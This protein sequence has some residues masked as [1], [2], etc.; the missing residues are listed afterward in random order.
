M[1][2]TSLKAAL[3][4]CVLLV[5]MTIW[6]LQ[7]TIL[8]VIDHATIL[9][10]NGNQPIRNGVIVIEGQ[11]IRDIG[12]RGNIRPGPGVTILDANGKWVI[13]GLIDAHVHFDQSG[14][15]FTRPDAIDL[16]EI[17]PYE[18]EL[19]WIKERLPVTLLRYPA[20]G[21]TSVVDMGG[22]MW[23][24]EV[25]DTAE[26]TPGAPRVAVAGPL[27]S[28]QAIPQLESSDP[29]VIRAESPDRARELVRRVAERRPDLIKILFVLE[30][31]DDPNAKAAIVAA[32][33]DESHKQGIRAAVHATELSS[34]KAAV[35]AGADVLVHSVENQRVDLEFVD[36]LT[37]RKVLYIPTLAVVEGYDKVFRQAVSLTDI[38]RRLGDPQVIESW[39]ELAKV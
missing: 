25:R 20:S 24:F 16:R 22:P 2:K 33:I 9:D 15:I 39:A 14:N 17:R 19:T 6:A 28:T 29:A 35:R 4:V 5:S 12:T 8:L 30:A 13:P 34:A 18:A 23:S 36:L 1:L 32:A 11:R 38:E 26:K 21:V 31:G 3:V 7:L 37:S 10:G 27:I